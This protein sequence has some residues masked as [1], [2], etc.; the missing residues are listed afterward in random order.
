MSPQK[1][2]DDW[3]EYKRLV[4]SELER[5]NALCEKQRT[6]I[7]SLENE[8]H[9]LSATSKFISSDNKNKTAIWV[10]AITLVGTLLASIISLI[11][12]I[13]K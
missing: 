1:Q 10:A 6:D 5:L 3:N 7:G 9:R 4:M 13:N 8:V 12:S 11:V 2:S